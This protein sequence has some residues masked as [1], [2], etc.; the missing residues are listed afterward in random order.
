MGRQPRRDGCLPAGFCP[1]PACNVAHKDV[2]N[3]LGER[4]GG[5]ERDPAAVACS[6][7]ARIAVAAV[8]LGATAIR[9]AL[10][11]ATAAGSRSLAADALASQVDDVL[12]GHVV[13]AGSGQNPARQ[14]AVAAGPPTHVPALTLNKVCLA[15][16]AA[17]AIADQLIRA[18]DIEVAVAGGMESMSQAP[19]LLRSESVASTPRRRHR[20]RRPR[21]RR[22][23]VDLYVPAH[24]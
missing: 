21:S 2:V 3:L 4:V 18:G 8:E 24:G 5:E 7:A 20:C 13:Q 16:L 6:R 10:E 15:S 9:A 12:M 1:E 22:A 17:I 14:A 23:L 19:Y 11:Q